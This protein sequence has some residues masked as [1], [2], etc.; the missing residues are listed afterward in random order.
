MTRTHRP[1]AEPGDPGGEF[2]HPVTDTEPGTPGNHDTSPARGTQAE[3]GFTPSVQGEPGF[4]PDTHAGASF[5][6]GAQGK[7]GFT[8]GVRGEPGFAPGAHTEPGF[9]PGTHA[10]A[11]TGAEAGAPAERGRQ[12]L[13][14]TG[15]LV[16]TLMLAMAAVLIGGSS[17]VRT[18]DAAE[19]PGEGNGMPEASTIVKP[20]PTPSRLSSTAP[21]R[22]A[23]PTVS[24]TVAGAN[25]P[26]ASRTPA[27]YQAPS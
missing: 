18:L 15:V 5:T 9:A 25:P 1:Q 27:G 21:G 24:G 8:P 23:L 2:T 16:G 14:A 13:M 20:T 12:A 22:S 6:S 3:P 10:G 17:T 11:G 19:W 26:A 7:P 4:T